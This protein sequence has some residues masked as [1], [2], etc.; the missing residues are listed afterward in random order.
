MCRGDFERKAPMWQERTPGRERTRQRRNRRAGSDYQEVRLSPETRRSIGR[1]GLELRDECRGA[2]YKPAFPERDDKRWLV[3]SLRWS[4]LVVALLAAST[5]FMGLRRRR[6]GTFRT[7]RAGGA[8]LG[9]GRVSPRRRDEA[10]TMSPD[11]L[12]APLGARAT[13][14]QFSARTCAVCPQVRRTLADVA[15]RHAGVVHV[16]VAADE[17][18]D[19]ATR[20][21]ILI[22]L[23]FVAFAYIGGI[24][25]V[26]G[27]VFGGLI[28]TEGLVSHFI[29]SGFN[30]D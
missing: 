6:D 23:S 21:G 30:N 24:T 13:L 26:S 16:E 2:H 19:L 28:A 1:R 29:E 4:L 9:D 22:A 3:T 18:L 14:V 15:G 8:H 12:G 11:D 7:S 27:A 25:M 10:E 17:R 5:A 20:F